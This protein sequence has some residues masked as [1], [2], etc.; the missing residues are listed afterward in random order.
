MDKRKILIVDDEEHIRELLEYNLFS[1]GYQ[2]IMAETGEEALKILEEEN[3]DLVLLDLMLPGIDGIEVCNTIRKDD[4]KKY[5]P[6][7]MVTAKGADSDR[8][9]GLEIGADDY[10]AKPFNM[11]ELKARIKAV[12]RRSQFG[13]KEDQTH[14]RYRD[15]LLDLENKECKK[16]GEEVL[17]TI[18]EFELLKLLIEHEGKV[19]SRNFLLDH[20]WGYDYF[21]ETRTVDVHIRHL[22]VKIGDGEENNYIETKRGIGY[23]MLR[24]E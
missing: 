20:I 9:L 6:I 11:G 17:L 23:R 5:I 13:K 24:E 22:R 4:E 2:T 19:L 21:G 3:V 1:E 14:Y 7:I 18:K 8:I 12:L 10:I 16:N 15:L